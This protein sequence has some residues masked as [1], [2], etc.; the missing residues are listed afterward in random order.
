M[1]IRELSPREALQ[2]QQAGALLLDVRETLEHA[3]GMAQGA[4][5]MPRGEVPRRIA[6]IAPDRNAEIL[7]LCAHGQ[8]S[9]MAAQVLQQL[10]YGNVASVAGGT[11]EWVAEGL[12]MAG[13]ENEDADFFE[14][15]SRHLRLPEVGEAGQCK[16]EDARVVIVGAGDRKSVV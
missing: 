15:Y 8:R 11:A 9:L 14:R 3:S 7:T 1:T 6:D 10:G 5:P 4:V 12:P 16:L 13:A 2:R